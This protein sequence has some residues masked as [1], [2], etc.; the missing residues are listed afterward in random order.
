MSRSIYTFYEE[1]NRDSALHY[2]QLRYSIAKK[3]NRKIEEAYCQGQMAYQQIY[4]G[5][6]SEALANLTTAIQIA[7]DTKDADTWELTPLIPL[8][9]PE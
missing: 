6:F 8:A 1:T 7:S 4:L 3:N 9:K 5:R 2:A